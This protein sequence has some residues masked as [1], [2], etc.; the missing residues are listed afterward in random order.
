MTQ[1]RDQVDDPVVVFPGTMG[2]RLADADGREVWGP[3]GEALLWEVRTIG[4][5]LK[6]GPHLLHRTS[7]VQA[8]TGRRGKT[9][10]PR[11]HGTRPFACRACHTP[12]GCGTSS[13]RSFA[14]RFAARFFARRSL[15]SSIIA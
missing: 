12:A 10:G 7:L 15:R 6:G 5:S 9:A 8:S 2:S 14:A 4:R 11:T 3:S 1:R 13:D